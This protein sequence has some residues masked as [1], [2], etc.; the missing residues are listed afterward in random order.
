MNRQSNAGSLPALFLRSDYRQNHRQHAQQ[1][2]LHHQVAPRKLFA[3]SGAL[4]SAGTENARPRPGERQ[5]FHS[6]FNEVAGK[7]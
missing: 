7:L 2:K 6:D 1:A 4:E 3:I 5:H